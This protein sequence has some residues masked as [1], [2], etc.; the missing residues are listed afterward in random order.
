MSTRSRIGILKKDGSIDSIYCHLDGYPEWVGQKLYRFYN[1][2]E[3]INSLIN[4]GAISHLEENLEPNPNMKHEFGH[5]TEQ[6]NVVVAYHRDRKEDWK[7]VKPK[8]FKDINEFEDYCKQSD[9][10]YAYLYDVNNESYIW[11]EI[12]WNTNEKMEF[13]SLKVKLIELGVI[14]LNEEKLDEIIWK[15]IDYEKDN[16]LYEFNNNFENDNDAFKSLKNYF[17][18]NGFDDYKNSLKDNIMYLEDDKSDLVLGNLY[19]KA[20]SLL[21]DIN[22]FEKDSDIEI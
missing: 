1:N 8:H 11:S 20:N 18:N 19:E 5:D 22:N 10:E 15:A 21:K 4:L 12:P 2:L 14:D 7:Y 3:K 17:C 6:P 9:Q 13:S 16:D